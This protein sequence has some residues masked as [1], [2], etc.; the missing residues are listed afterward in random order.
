MR[1][2]RPTR[3]ILLSSSLVVKLLKRDKDHATKSVDNKKVL[4]PNYL[5]KEDQMA[6]H[7]RRFAAKVPEHRTQSSTTLQ[8][9]CW[10]LR[11]QFF[12]RRGPAPSLSQCARMV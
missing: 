4:A 11:S 2:S 7:N 3:T 8:T 9:V 5:S 12:Q 10:Q 6:S 1:K